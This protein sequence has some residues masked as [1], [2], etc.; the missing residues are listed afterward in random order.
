MSQKPGSRQGSFTSRPPPPPPP[1]IPP[2]PGTPPEPRS[3]PPP[4]PTGASAAPPLVPRRRESLDTNNTTAGQGSGPLND[5]PLTGSPNISSRSAFRSVS[6]NCASVQSTSTSMTSPPPSYIAGSVGGVGSSSPATRPASAFSTLPTSSPSLPSRPNTNTP[7]SMSSQPSLK[8]RGEDAATLTRT[9]ELRPNLNL[10]PK[11]QESHSVDSRREDLRGSCLYE[12]K[13]LTQDA[14]KVLHEFYQS[15]Q[16]C[17]LELKVGEKVFKCHRVVLA[18]VSKYFRAMFTSEMAESKQNRVTIQDI[19]EYAME[20]LIKFAYTGKVLITVNN[21][22]PMLYA[23]SILQVEAVAIASSDFMKTHMHP[24]NCI[25]IRQFAEA[26]G[27]SELI[28]MADKFIQDNFQDVVEVE[29]FVSMT[30]EH[31]ELIIASP[32]IF[33]ESEIQ[34]Y[35][36]VMKWLMH[37]LE[38]RKQYLARL[39]AHVKF[40][41]L[42]ASYLMGKVE[43]EPMM[44]KDLDCRDYIDEAKHYQLFLSGVYPTVKLSERLRPR[45]SCAG[46][47]FCVGGR[48]GTGDPFKSIECYDLRNNRWLTIS[49]MT[50]KRRHVGVVSVDGLLYSI[51]GHDGNEHL[52]SCEVFDPVTNKWKAIASMA[53]YRRGIAVASLNGPIYVVGGLDD[54]TCFN[55]VERYDIQSDSW[56]FVAPMNTPRGGVGVG[57][58]KNMLYAVGGNDGT[59]SL[60][61]CERYD[62]HVNR[63]TFVASMKKRR[64]G[65]GVA[66]LD[67]YLFVVGGFDDNSP[68]DS[69]ERY[70]PV[71]NTW[72]VL[73]VMSRPRGGVGV[74]ALG[75]K[76]YAVGG[77]D[78][79]NY[80]NSVEAFDPISNSWDSAAGVQSGR[81]G[82]GVT[83]VDCLIHSIRKQDKLH[84]SSTA[85]KL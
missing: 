23:A 29:E 58:L 73:T 20:L 76:I 74:A 15:G 83:V 61:T 79:T 38:H 9:M 82:A 40:P 16:L 77:H 11:N 85:G 8:A 34:A 67:G 80:L 5:R 64:A 22:Q 42:P 45:K 69:V 24:T 19:D 71:T 78:G 1:V 27:R 4:L 75:G 10:V 12:A 25:G 14:F 21:V 47:M 3:N 30:T 7:E 6:S 48:G 41:L 51:G 53:T 35:E 50:T 17:D 56:S 52:N 2:P 43:Q 26:H 63:W 55:Q 31:L 46:V 13:S 57:A 62:P 28:K 18:C 32:N 72:E 36:A 59:T 49:E 68:Q 84:L 66:V 60:D 33:V 37:D 65:A 81:A 44:K 54:S 39:M 70:D